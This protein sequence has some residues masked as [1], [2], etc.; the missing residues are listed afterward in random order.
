VRISER[1]TKTLEEIA[2]I[3]QE[4]CAFA[5]DYEPGDERYRMHRW[6]PQVLLVCDRLPDDDQTKDEVG[7]P[8]LKKYAEQNTVLVVR[9]RSSEDIS[10]DELVPHTLPLERSDTGDLDVL[11]VLLSIA[12]K[13]MIAL[14]IRMREQQ[15]NNSNRF[16]VKL[17]G[18]DIPLGFDSIVRRHPAMWAAAMTEVAR[19]HGCDGMNIYDWPAQRIA[20]GVSGHPYELEQDPWRERWKPGYE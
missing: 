10:L 6:Y 5:K 16:D 2:E 13:Y 8:S 20:A 3:H 14:E 1:G 9:T 15:G 18:I 19:T 12:V 7:N 17:R 11:R 4:I